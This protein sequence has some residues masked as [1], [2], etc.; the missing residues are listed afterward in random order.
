MLL[1]TRVYKSLFMS[2]FLVLW[3]IHPEVEML[4]RMVTRC[5]IFWGTTILFSPAAA[6]IYIPTNGNC[7]LILY[8]IFRPAK[9]FAMDGF[10]HYYL[11]RLPCSIAVAKGEG[12]SGE[13]VC[14]RAPC[15][16]EK[17]AINGHTTTSII[18]NFEPCYQRKELASRRRRGETRF[19]W[20]KVRVRQGNL[21]WRLE[22]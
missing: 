19:G 1:Q 4:Y 21:N 10:I 18:I 2:L 20:G 5:L 22:T 9:S 11:L 12:L 7:L 6:P 14:L 17:Q 15:T 16:V 13:G 8:F 3:G